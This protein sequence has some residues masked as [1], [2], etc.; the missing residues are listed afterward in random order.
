MKKGF[1]KQIKCALYA[2]GLF[3]DSLMISGIRI[4][5]KTFGDPTSMSELAF[6]QPYYFVV[7]SVGTNEFIFH[8]IWAYMELMKVKVIIF[9][10]SE[11]P[12]LVVT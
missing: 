9:Y 8:S 11:F 2:W 3:I 12:Q 4:S 10:R 6:I 5:T 7:Y 1:S